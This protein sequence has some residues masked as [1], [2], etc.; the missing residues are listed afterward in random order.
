MRFSLATM[1][2][3]LSSAASAAS[4]W[5]FTDGSVT[6]GL[7]GSEGVTE[8]YVTQAPPINWH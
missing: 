5:D 1:L 7:K 4:Q 8:K 2:L 3:A 6:V